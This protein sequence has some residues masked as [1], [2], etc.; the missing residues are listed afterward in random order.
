[1]TRHL[2]ELGRNKIMERINAIKN[3]EEVRDDILSSILKGL[4]MFGYVKLFK[5]PIFKQDL[6][7]RKKN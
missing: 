5:K 7:K 6:I 4:S 3:N 1:M 2:R